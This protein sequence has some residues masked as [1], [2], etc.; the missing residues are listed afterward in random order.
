ML[1]RHLQRASIANGLRRQKRD[2]SFVDLSNEHLIHNISQM[3]TFVK[4]TDSCRF[5]VHFIDHLKFLFCYLGL[6]F[7]SGYI[8]IV[9]FYICIFFALLYMIVKYFLMPNFTAL[10]KLLPVSEYTFSFVYLGFCLFIPDYL[11]AALA[12]IADDN[13]HFSLS[14]SQ[15]EGEILRFFT[16]SILPLCMLGYRVSG[17]LIWA[18]LLFIFLGAVYMFWAVKVKYKLYGR[19]DL[20]YVDSHSLR[21]NAVT[22]LGVFVV[23]IIFSL[24]VS[25]QHVRRQQKEELEVE[26][27]Y[28]NSEVS[29]EEDLEYA[30][31]KRRDLKRWQVWWHTVNAFRNMNETHHW[32][33]IV[34]SP[35][36]FLAAH[37]LPVID[38]SRD[39][40]GW[41]KPVVA[42][43]FIVLPFIFI[44]IHPPASVFMSIVIT[45]WSLCL[46]ILCTTQT[47]Q[48]PSKLG[49]GIFCVISMIICSCALNTL[50][51]E[52]DNLI[53]QYFCMRFQQ[54]PDAI[55]LTLMCSGEMVAQV[56]VLQYLVDRNMVDAA[57]GSAMSMITHTVY[58]AVP[59]LVLQSCYK[60]NYILVSSSSETCNVFFLLIC[61]GSLLHISMSGYEFRMSLFFYMLAMD[62]AYFTFIYYF[63]HDWLRSFGAFN[64]I[65][66]PFESKKV[67]A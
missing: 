12:C 52:V 26:E 6:P 45:S 56:I 29:S 14:F 9:A 66:P 39:M 50:S 48:E 43:S 64:Y 53:Y 10:M 37:I 62:M 61:F 24:I 13:I 32:L 41:C 60:D 40:S 4:N 19:D 47:L 28:N 59:L 58:T 3:C 2:N 67:W 38:H 46:F 1:L 7:Y 17:L 11:Q 16:V 51:T 21:L 8:F 36:Y 55:V 15:L 49:L 33:V 54:N 30:T 25:Y 57:Y 27:Y 18:N 20:P 5:Y 22:F 23:V 63:S 44:G 65:L 42:F 31:P 34:L 35:F